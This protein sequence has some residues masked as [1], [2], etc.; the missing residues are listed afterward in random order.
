MLEGKTKSSTSTFN[1]FVRPRDLVRLTS[2]GY[3]GRFAAFE[4]KEIF[5]EMQIFRINQRS[6]ALGTFLFF[7]IV[8]LPSGCKVK[9]KIKVPVPA[10]ILLDKTATYEE[11][12]NIV[13]RNNEQLGKINALASNLDLI[14]TVGKKESG[15][16]EEYKRGSGFI[17]LKRPDSLFIKIQEFSFTILEILT[18]GDEFKVWKRGNELYIGKNSFKGEL[19]P[20]NAPDGKGYD[21]PA[22]PQQFFEAILPEP[23]NLDSPDIEI[24]MEEQSGIEA[25]YFV[26]CF[27][28]PIAA[29]RRYVFRKI[30]IERT[31]LTIAK[32]QTYTVGGK[33]V[34]DTQY[35]HEIQIDSFSLPHEINMDRPLDGYSLKLKV[36]QWRVNNPEVLNAGFKIDHPGAKEI[37]L[38]EK[39]KSDAD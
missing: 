10:N 32:Q 6:V 38:M 21:F 39:K 9:N 14:L 31:G 30:W 7:L 5:P 3:F 34:S 8:G 18:I 37:H 1:Y 26:L 27:S 24:W 35:S 28:K 2:L 17:Q 13:R 12:L 11:L 36:A 4:T 20:E 23:I 22:R 29:N 15:V 19:V 33:I 16:L 25:R